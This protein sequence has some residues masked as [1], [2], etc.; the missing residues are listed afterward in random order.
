MG[1]WFIM[2]LKKKDLMSDIKSESRRTKVYK[3]LE[4]QFKNPLLHKAISG[5]IVYVP[6]NKEKLWG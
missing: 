4:Q 6:L 5:D 1:E 3:E 2:S